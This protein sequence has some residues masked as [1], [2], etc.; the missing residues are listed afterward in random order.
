MHKFE[1][2]YKFHI[3]NRFTE[4]VQKD[5]FTLR[6]YHRD[7]IMKKLVKIF[8]NMCTQLERRIDQDEVTVSQLVTEANAADLLTV[9]NG[10]RVFQAIDRQKLSFRDLSESLISKLETMIT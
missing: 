5:F 1:S 7:T 3:E 9:D 4:M 8:E 10:R 2:L 6:K